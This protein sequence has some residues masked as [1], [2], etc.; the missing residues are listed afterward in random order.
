VVHEDRLAADD[1]SSQGSSSSTSYPVT[2]RV[3][4]GAGFVQGGTASV[5]LAVKTVKN[6]VTVPN[7]ALHGSTVDVLAKGKVT[8]V[9]V[10]TG[11][12]GAL[13]TQVTSGLTRVRSWCWLT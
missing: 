5:G 2:V 10:Q 3:A 1:S 4:R 6:V 9:E 11:A 12:V 13:A 7:S 8:T